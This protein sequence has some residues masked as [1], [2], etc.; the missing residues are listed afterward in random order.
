MQNRAAVNGK[1]TVEVLRARSTEMLD[2]LRACVEIETPSRDKAR[3]DAFVPFFTELATRYGGRCERI[4]NRD[5]GDHL[6]VR[7]EKSGEAPV[8]FLG[9]YD[10]VWPAGT[11]ARKPF[12]V[13]DGVARGPGV[14]DMKAGLVQALWAARLV[15]ANGSA[16]PPITF[17][18]NSDE[19]IG[20]VT[21]RAM[22]EDEARKA[23]AVF[24]FEP[25]FHGAVKT[26]RKGVGIYT[27]E[28]EGRAAH[29]GSEP[30]NGINAIDELARATL[31]IHALG[32][33]K[34]G[35]SIYVDVVSG[36]TVRNTIAAHARG[37]IDMRAATNAEAK[38]ID[39]ALH[40]LRPHHPEAKLTITGGLNRPPM[41]RS[42]KI[43]DLYARA[44]AIAMQLGFA[45]E[46]ASVGGGSD[47]N[48]AAAVGAGV[49]DGI[50]AVGEGAHAEHEHVHVG[51]MAERTA[52]VIDLVRSLAA[53]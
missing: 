12:T 44:K 24:V 18:V 22:I 21:S 34:A 8:L 26:A 36:G 4:A 46:E 9:H 47:G 13:T 6:V 53:G 42:P 23:R 2:D 14:F 1:A 29:A 52:L 27:V 41:E 7:W 51:A 20:S 19:E 37:E 35:T 31:A 15:H 39:D 38:R 49:L 5:G 30:E 45:L 32:N 50:G 3:C 48:F 11:L 17:V 25:S 16:A 43:A 40:A 10:T 33:P 28:V